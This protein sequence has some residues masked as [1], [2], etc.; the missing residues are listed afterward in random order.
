MLSKMDNFELNISKLMN[1]YYIPTF[2]G[3]V[4]FK[5]RGEVTIRLNKWNIFN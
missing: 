1:N 3:N 2:N 4:I 5:V